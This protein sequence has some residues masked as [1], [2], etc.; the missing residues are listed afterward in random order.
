VKSEPAMNPIIVSSDE[1]DEPR[2]QPT[3]MGFQWD[4]KKEV[5][6]AVADLNKK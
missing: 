4:W 6:R 3:R 2:V 1:E 5:T